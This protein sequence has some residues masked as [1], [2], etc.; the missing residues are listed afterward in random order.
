MAIHYPQ[1]INVMIAQL[2]ISCFAGHCCGLE[3][4]ELSKII[5]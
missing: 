4:L 2:G 1:D 5:D 3:A